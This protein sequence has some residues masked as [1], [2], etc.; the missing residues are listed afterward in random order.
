MPSLSALDAAWAAERWPLTL[1]RVATLDAASED[2]APGAGLSVVVPDDGGALAWRHDPARVAPALVARLQARLAAF[3]TDLARGAPVAEASVLAPD[4][5]SDLRS[6]NAT[7]AA[8][9][10]EE[11]IHAAIA[12]QVRRTPSRAAVVAGRTTLSYAALDARANR[13]ARL[14][15]R[16]GVRR[17]DLVGVLADRDA[18]LVVALLAILKAGAAYVPLDPEFPADRLA[19]MTEDADLRLVVAKRRTAPAAPVAAERLLVLDDVELALAAEDGDAPDT[20]AER[21]DLAYVI[22]TS[23]STGRPKGVMLEH[24]NVLNFMAGMDA[25]LRPGADP[26]TWLAVTS[27]SFDISV[28]ELLWT[29][30]RGFTV[31]LYAGDDRRRPAAPPA[32]APASAAG[33]A[34]GAGAHGAHAPLELSLFYFSSDADEPG[35]RYR[36]LLEGA[37][38]ADAHGFSAV[39]TPERHFHA[40]GGLF[41]NPAVAGAAVAAI[42]QRVRIRAGSCV[43][44]LH[45]PIRVAEEW[46]VV[47][48][49]SDGRVDISF[50]SGWQPD[51]FVLAPANHAERNEVMAS[52][53]ETVR[54][55]W[56]GEARTFDGPDGRPVTVRTLPRPVQPELPFWVTAAGNPATFRSAGAMGANLLTHLLGQDLVQLEAKVRAYREAWAAAG[57]PGRGHV[58]LMLHTFV[59]PD[60]DAVRAIVRGPLRG[61]LQSSA[62]LM[63]QY[64]SSFPAFRGTDAAD[65]A[66]LDAA[67]RGMAE[68]D[69]DALLEHAYERYY[70]TSGL[71]GTVDEA[72]ATAERVRAADVDEI[73]CLIDFGIP[74]DTV[75]A[76]L[77]DLARLREALA[78]AAA[79]SSIPDLVARHGVAHLQCTPSMA[80]ML[81]ADAAGRAALGSLERMLVGGEALPREL[82]RTLAALVPGEVVNVYGPTETTIWSTVQPLRG[83]AVDGTA[84]VVAI[85]TPIANTEAYVC[86]EALQPLPAGVPGELVLGGAGVARGYWRRPELSAERFVPDRIAAAVGVAPAV[87]DGRLYRTGDL[88]RWGSDG[89]LEYLGR[90][91][92][93]VKVRGHRIEL[94]E[95]EATLDEHPLVRQ[96]V[97][98]ARPGEGGDARLVAYVLP[99][100]AERPGTAALRDHAAARLPAPMVPHAYVVLDAFPLTPNRK[101]DRRALP[102]PAADDRDGDADYV[103]PS[104]DLEATLAD[105]WRRVLSVERVGAHDDFFALG[106][107]SLLAVFATTEV[108]KR[109]Y[110]M[111][112]AQLLGAPTVARLA[113][114]LTPVPGAGEQRRAAAGTAA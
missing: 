52:G 64:A 107:N 75:L 112:L 82:A 7:A 83:E 111:T 2:A 74:T 31:V 4:D 61:Y 25:H 105:V 39:W 88:T 50:A 23:G 30:A 29:L 59:G 37:R 93:Q 19:F 70:A 46:A 9:P 28:L 10:P 109:G 42:T 57:H 21:D 53:I 103:A 101:V 62:A 49:L 113:P 58:S 81:V 12:A 92:F 18:D 98:V 45:H 96:A 54:A 102:E 35:Q 91:D 60:P 68:A 100:G 1:E 32:A 85:G 89:V 40:F 41:P 3:L 106:G 14:L 8:L 110:R 13:L 17:G 69:L 56:R 66:S 78:A 26:G 80:Q 67:F 47:D 95:I 104:G 90:L 51:D 79:P 15:A 71:F 33:G 108:A 43:L 77:H 87:T 6:W 38:F 99:A 22:Y 63:R 73:A 94:G 72:L 86:D 76:G 24:G 48:N 5:R 65:A 84:P 55:L 97:V 16:R 27:I 114:L 34:H 20:G 36:L 44:P 11:T